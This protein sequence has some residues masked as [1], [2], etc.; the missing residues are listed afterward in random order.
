MKDLAQT[1]PVGVQITDSLDGLAAIH[2]SDCAAV[3]WA[4]PDCPALSDWLAA[5]PADAL[6]QMRQI[7]RPEAAA[8]ALHALCACMPEGPERVTF[9]ESAALLAERFAAVMRAPWLRLRLEVV[10]GDA[11]RKF[12]VD[13]VTARLVCT[14]R[15][16][17]TQLG[18]AARGA[19]PEM[20][21]TVPTG[22]PIIL[23]GMQWPTTPP[24]LLKHRS[25]PIAGTGE[26]RLLLVLDPILDPE[27]EV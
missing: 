27:D 6:P 10:T 11:C 26:A 23:R 9:I 4:R 17:G 14:Y 16:T 7:L 12:H 1:Q 25:P 18:L 21:H 19:E 13:N 22:Q 3:I 2:A 5:L 24:S 15:G 8:P 20:I